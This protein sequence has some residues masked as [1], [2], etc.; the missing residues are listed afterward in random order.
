MDDDDA[1]PIENEIA[2]RRLAIAI[3]CLVHIHLDVVGLRG[4]ILRVLEFQITMLSISDT[5]TTLLTISSDRSQGV[6][7]RP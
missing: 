1:I 4:V 6:G 3:L 2:Y 7:S 5:H